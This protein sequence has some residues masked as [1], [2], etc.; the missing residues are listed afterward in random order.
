MQTLQNDFL[1]KQ[2][3]RQQFKCSN[4]IFHMISQRQWRQKDEKKL[5]RTKQRA[6]EKWHGN[7]ARLGLSFYNDELISV[8]LFAWIS[9]V[10]KF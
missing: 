6:E 9:F 7:M 5:E 4:N 1:Q 10:L 2:K 8:H 3:Q